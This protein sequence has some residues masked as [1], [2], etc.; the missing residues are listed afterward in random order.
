MDNLLS[1]TPPSPS[2][3]KRLSRPLNAWFATT[4]SGLEHLDR[5]R[6]ALY[7]GNHTI[8]GYD[9]SSLITG[10]YLKKNIYLRGV[11]DRIHFQIPFWGNFLQR[12][13]AFEGTRE[14]IHELMQMG[15]HILLY[16]GGGREVLKN[17]GEAYQLV[18][19][20]RYGFIELALAHGYDIIPFAAIG[21]EELVDIKY[22]S[23]DFR[24]SL[25]GKGLQRVGILQ[26]M[27]N[28]EA[29]IP[30]T[31]GFL[32]IPFIPKRHALHFKF[33]PR[34]ETYQIPIEQHEAVKA[35]LRTRVATAIEEALSQKTHL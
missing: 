20:S 6:P 35:E 23:N 18:W 17:K 1:F 5:M 30:I 11:G 31:T 32:G 12:Y 34:I 14:S 9:V 4:F 19:K 15:E 3:I 33:C 25:L 7:I 29:F 26:R 13:G 27:R 24:K 21:G 16:P 10:L 2:K 28:G 22:D 8:M